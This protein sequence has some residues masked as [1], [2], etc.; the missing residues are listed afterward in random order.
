MGEKLKKRIP[1]HIKRRL[2]TL[3][4]GTFPLL[5]KRLARALHPPSIPHNADG[6]VLIHLGCGDQDDMRF[7]NVDAI[8]FPHVHFVHAVNR[9]GMFSSNYA[10]MVYASHVLEHVSYKYLTEILREWCRVLKV[11]GTLRISV[12]D[13]ERIL[14]IYK[15]E[16][17]SIEK[18][19][20]PLLGGQ[21]YAY[22]FHMS[23]FNKTYLSKLLREAGFTDIREWDPKTALYY[24]FSDWASKSLYNKY[25]ISLNLE[26]TKHE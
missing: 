24:S 17:G 2:N 9:L 14:D 8:P 10:D 20:G 3:R 26:A 16:N 11:G 12:P 23:V 7:I 18:I 13:F 1:I 25:P 5:K 6:K 4:Y 21:N 15:A 22:N 19:E